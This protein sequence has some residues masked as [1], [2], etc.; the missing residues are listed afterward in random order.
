[1][2]DA[3][4]GLSP[5]AEHIDLLQQLYLYVDGCVKPLFFVV[6]ICFSSTT[7]HLGATIGVGL[8]FDKMVRPVLGRP[9]RPINTR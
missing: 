4:R 9:M 6:P 1:M 7:T 2:K 8:A 3:A 5:A